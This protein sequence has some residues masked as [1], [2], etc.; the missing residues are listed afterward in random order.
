MPDEPDFAAIFAEMDALGFSPLQEE[1][2]RETVTADTRLRESFREITAFV[3]KNGREPRKGMNMKELELAARLA[4]FRENPAKAQAVLDMD[5][6]GLLPHEDTS[7]EEVMNSLSLPSCEE[8]IFDVSGLPAPRNKP[9]YVASRKPCKDFERYR[10]LFEQCQKDLMQNRRHIVR[11]AGNRRPSGLG[12]GSFAVVR[13]VLCY[14]AD[15]SSEVTWQFHRQ[16][17][18]LRVI[19]ENGTESDILLLSLVRALYE[20][21]CLISERDEDTLND[22]VLGEDDQETGIIYILKSKSS[23][24]QIQQ[25]P[26]LCKIGVSTQRLEDRIAHAE[27]EPT[28]LMAKVEP[29]GLFTCYNVNVQKLEALLHRLFAEAQVVVDVVDDQGQVCHPHEWFS[30]PISVI[31]QAVDMI[32]DGSIIGYRY[33]VRT[34]RMVW[35]GED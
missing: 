10:H 17:R 28:Y 14:I 11:V 19:Y 35:K 24:P 27:H 20:N 18:R 8:D 23:D 26:N 12:K 21:G 31:R 34:Q 30:V 15:E 1:K 29:I 5:S 4:E 2:K 6:S 3:E 22:M 33:D 25:I 13:H 32:L 7:L 9:D 16:N